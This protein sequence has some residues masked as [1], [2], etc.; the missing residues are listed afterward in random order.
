VN[1]QSTTAGQ[2]LPDG[3]GATS[4]QQAAQV[5]QD[6]EQLREERDKFLTLLQRTRADFENYQKRSSRDLEQERRYAYTPLVRDLL[7]AIDNLERAL[8]SVQEETA[9]SKGVAMVH[10]LLMDTLK[11]HGIT[12]IEAVGQPFDPNY[13]Q[14]VMQQ[15][16]ANQPP[17]TV[18]QVLAPGYLYH[19]RV[20]RPSSVVVSKAVD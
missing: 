7:T 8:A 19:D 12:R 3:E 13:H 16:A 17:N 10:T 11:R 14:A 5:V 15:P 18:L 2:T 6:L 20:L 4:E 9:L 1:E